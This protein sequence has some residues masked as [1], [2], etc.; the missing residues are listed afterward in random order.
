MSANLM[1]LGGLSIAIGMLVDAAVVM[2]ENIVQRLGHD[3][4]LAGFLDCTP[5][6]ERFCEVAVPVTSGI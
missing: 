1:S 3:L 4:P 2:V 5:F 6:T